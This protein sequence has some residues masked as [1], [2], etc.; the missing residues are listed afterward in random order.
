MPAPPACRSKIFLLKGTIILPEKIIPL[1]SPVIFLPKK[2]ISLGRKTFAQV[3]KKVFRVREMKV[4]PRKIPTS[5][6]KTFP[7]RRKMNCLPRK[8][9][10][11]PRKMPSLTKSSLNPSA[12]HRDPINPPASGFSLSIFCPLPCLEMGHAKEAEGNGFFKR[13]SGHVLSQK[14][15][16]TNQ[17]SSL[18][19][20][21]S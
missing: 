6:K 5:C 18:K 7:L 4:L 16:A 15:L 11:F 8:L 14:C 21:S 1:P 3:R 12:S 20:V 2:I 13:C 17:G 10:D 19:S 9:V